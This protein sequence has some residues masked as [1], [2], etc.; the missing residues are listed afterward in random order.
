[1]V[2]HWKLIGVFTVVVIIFVPYHYF[3]SDKNLNS[4]FVMSKLYG[5]ASLIHC[6]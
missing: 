6:H 2:Y 1:M 5:K 4:I 3:C